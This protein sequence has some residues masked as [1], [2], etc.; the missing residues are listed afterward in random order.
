M[1]PKVAVGFVGIDLEMASRCSRFGIYESNA[2]R[3]SRFGRQ[4]KCVRPA[5]IFAHWWFSEVVVLWYICIKLRIYVLYFYCRIRLTYLLIVHTLWNIVS[6]QSIILSVFTTDSVRVCFQMSHCN[7]SALARS[8][9]RQF[10]CLFRVL[11]ITRI[12]LHIWHDDHV[13]LHI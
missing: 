3:R 5:R 10:S 9:C 13:R 2:T 4:L 1:R 6:T 11:F 7:A 8:G 12:A